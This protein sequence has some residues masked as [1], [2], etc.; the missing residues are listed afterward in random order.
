MIAVTATTAPTATPTMV[1]VET[2][3]DICVG[4]VVEVA[5]EVDDGTTL[6]VEVGELEVIQLAL[7]DRATISVSEDPPERPWASV[8]EKTIVVP[9]ATSAIHVKLVPVE[10]GYRMNESPPGMSP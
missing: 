9:A 5:T 8:N 10:G 4:D 6:T 7:V 1:P 3:V 2:P